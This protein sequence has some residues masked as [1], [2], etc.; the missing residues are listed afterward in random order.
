MRSSIGLILILLVGL[1]VLASGCISS[2]SSTSTTSST[3]AT[4]TVPETGIDF[5]KYPPGGVIGHWNEIFGKTFYVSPGYEGMVKAYFPDAVIKP[6]SEY[7]GSG[8]AVLSPGEGRPKLRG[9]PVHITKLD[10]FGYVAYRYGLDFPGPWEGVIAALNS[11]KGGTLIITGTSRAGVGAAL[12]FLRGV[13]EG[14][15]TVDRNALVRKSD[16]EGLV[17]KEI[18]DVNMNGVPDKG[19]LVKLYQLSFEEPFQYYWRVIGGENVTVSGGF[20]KLVNGTT[21]YIRALGFNVTV[22]VRNPVGLNLTYVVE[23]VNPDFLNLPEGARVNGTEVIV[24]TSGSFSLTPKPVQDYYVLAFGD[25]R[26]PS[27]DEVPGVFL[28]I[29][30]DVN[31]ETGAFIIDGGDLVYSGTIWQ[32]DNLMKVWKWNKPIFIAPGNHEY[33]GEGISV[34]H[35]LFGPT[36]YAFSLGGYRYIFDNDVMGD[37]VLSEK[38]LQW[39]KEQMEIARKRGER[40]VVVM[41]APPYDPR[42]GGDDHAMDAESAKKLLELMKTYGAFGIFS[43]IHIYWDGTYDGVHFIITGGG[44]APLY[45][46]EN[47]GG[48][49]H[50]VVLDMKAGG[51]IG[52]KVIKVS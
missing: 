32:W 5:G 24:N 17:V 37:Y 19:E 31:N 12:N 52:V 4:S 27:G 8:I 1:S 42:P 34:Y 30:S 35:Y 29:I 3:S 21:V 46:P 41:H 18:G 43:H 7:D 33:Q 26:P 45:A 39:I 25:H 2:S 23:N 22:N 49:Y 20:I 38:Q 48:F 13:E 40:P 44:G 16:F 6:A 10:Y 51:D 36:E 47:E 50:Y 15:L 14:K 28:K 9:K 11:D